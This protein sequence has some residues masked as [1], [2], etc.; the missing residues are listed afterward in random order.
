MEEDLRQSTAPWK[1]AFF[2]HPPWSSGAH[3]SQLLMRREFAPLFEK[4]GVDLV[5]TGHDHDYERTKPMVG[6]LEAPSGTS[7]PT[8]VVVG[9]GGAAL[10]PLSEATRPSWSV[11]RN[12]ADHGYLDVTVREGTLNAQL[13]TPSGKVVDSFTLS[14]TLPPLPSPPE[15]Y[16]TAPDTGSGTPPASGTSPAPQDPSATTSDLPGGQDDSQSPGPT[17]LGCSADPVMELLPMGVWVLAGALR[18]RRR[19]PR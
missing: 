14:K 19:N 9:S 15:T 2:H 12:N 4:Y 11:L 13:V 18:R 6:N 3:G 17:A 10:R 16:P 1:V 8:Y 5:L 7:A